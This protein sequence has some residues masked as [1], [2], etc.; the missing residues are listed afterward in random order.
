MPKSNVDY[1]QPQI[2]R[3]KERDAEH[4]RR[5]A[6]L[7]WKALPDYPCP[8]KA[9]PDKGYSLT[10]CISMETMR[11]EGIRE[12]LT[13]DNHSTQEGFAILL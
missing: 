5:L 3:N 6:D 2:A 11:A 9:R 12:I 13:H 10:D 4:L 1:W 8:C 7:G